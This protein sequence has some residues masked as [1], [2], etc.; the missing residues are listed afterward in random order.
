MQKNNFIYLDPH[1]V[2]EAEFKDLQ[3]HLNTYNCLNFRS[4]EDS[5]VNPCLGISFT[6]KSF[7]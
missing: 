4:I 5:K 2:Q 3:K 1:F 6:M 7:D